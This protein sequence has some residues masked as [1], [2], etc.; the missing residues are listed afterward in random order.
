MQER[1]LHE[2]SGISGLY[3]FPEFLDSAAQRD[4]V[5]CIDASSEHW[6]E[7]LERRVQHYGWR[8]D[9]R[10]RTITSD[11]DLGALPDWVTKIAEQLAELKPSDGAK[12][13]D[14][15]PDQAIVNEYEPG[16][17]IALH[18]DRDCFGP[19]VATVS[20][21]DDWEMKFRPVKGTSHEDKRIMLVRGSALILTG[22]A[23]DCWMH[24]IDKRMTEENRQRKRK[25]RLSLTF[26]TVLNQSSD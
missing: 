13:F 15:V 6:R 17:G 12:L 5:K 21:G 3:Y 20:L 14:R 18:V 23:R 7:D 1:R 19:T 26:R 10:T 4:A 2:V 16:Q 24:G 22:E 9:Y 25:P 8:Y 11:M